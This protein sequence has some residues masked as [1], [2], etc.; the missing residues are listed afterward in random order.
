MKPHVS[1]LHGC[2]RA[3]YLHGF[4]S[5][6]SSGKA[7]FFAQRFSEEGIG[8]EIPQLDEGDFANLT[9]TKQLRA[10]ER[11]VNQEPVVLL[12]SS[13]GGYLAALYA[14]QH[15]EVSRLVLMAPAFYF[16]QRWP[17]SLGA[18]RTHNW[19][20]TGT[21]DVFHYGEGRIRQIGYSLIEDAMQYDG[22]PNFKQPALI[23]HGLADK[24]IPAAYSKEFAAGHLNVTLRL[25][26]SDH[27]LTDQIEV[28]WTETRR[29]L[30]LP[31]PT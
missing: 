16:P 25:L 4:A 26:D 13:M 2:K 12:G 11:V 10:V 7:Q 23:F 3:V 6:P 30:E 22:T 28:M 21:M 1:N 20:R 18:E 24:T 17:E 14:S 9:I 31:G 15:P 19:R 5:A 27:Q 29:F 8:L